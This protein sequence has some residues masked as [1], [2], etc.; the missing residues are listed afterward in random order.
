MNRIQLLIRT[1]IIEE[2]D[3]AVEDI[4][5]DIVNPYP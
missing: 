2:S 5:G 3:M 4:I 1:T